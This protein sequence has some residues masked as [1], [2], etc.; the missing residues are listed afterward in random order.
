LP[1]NDQVQQYALR[2][3]QKGYFVSPRAKQPILA[4]AE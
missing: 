2:F 1:K 3:L 4:A